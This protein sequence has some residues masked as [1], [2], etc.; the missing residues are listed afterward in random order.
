MSGLEKLTFALAHT[1]QTEVNA[2]KDSYK[3]RFSS[4]DRYSSVHQ[5]DLDTQ[6]QTFMAAI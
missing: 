3:N 5:R 2:S 6:T 4:K 1:D